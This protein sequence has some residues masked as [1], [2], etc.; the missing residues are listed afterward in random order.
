MPQLSCAIQRPLAIICS[1]LVSL[2][3][4]HDT[5]V[6]CLRT[7]TGD[8]AEV[9][10]ARIGRAGRAQLHGLPVHVALLHAAPLCWRHAP[11]VQRHSPQW[12]GP[13]WCEAAFPIRESYSL[14]P[15]HYEMSRRCSPSRVLMHDMSATLVCAVTHG[16]SLLMKAGSALSLEC[17]VLHSCEAH[18]LSLIDAYNPRV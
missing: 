10:A 14:W 9:R 17:L 2:C 6:V 4:D 16:L 5:A 7:I 18:V 13:H 8:I 3:P 11:H 15:W 12:H 1:F